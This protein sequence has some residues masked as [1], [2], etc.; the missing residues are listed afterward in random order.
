M[1]TNDPHQIERVL[2]TLTQRQLLQA[3]AQA[4]HRRN[5]ADVILG[6]LQHELHRRMVAPPAANGEDSALLKVEEVARVLKVGKARVNDLRYQGRLPFV[7]IGV[8][9]IRVRRS[10]L[11]QYLARTS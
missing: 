6:L 7:K 3:I 2:A 5:V 1:R 10:D 9:Q 8:R 4:Q 11:D